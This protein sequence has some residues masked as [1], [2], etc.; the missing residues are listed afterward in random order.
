MLGRDRLDPKAADYSAVLTK[1]KSL[2]PDALYYGGVGQAG[3]KLAKQAYDILPN[4]IKAGGDGI[5]AAD[6]LTGAGFPAVEG[7]YATI[8]APHVTGDPKIAEFI[9]RLQ[10]TLQCAARRLHDHLLYRGRAS[11]SRR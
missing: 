10:A 2:E 1:I 11:S 7:W 8:A 3:V 4:V 9:K 5:W 6:L